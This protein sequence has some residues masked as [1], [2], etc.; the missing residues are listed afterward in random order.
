MSALNSDHGE[1][2]E[3][4][5]S[6]QIVFNGSAYV[7]ARVEIDH[8]NY[9]LNPKTKEL[10]K[11]ARTDFTPDEIGEFLMRLDGEFLMPKSKKGTMARF[12]ADVDCPLNRRFHNKPFRMV[13][14]TNE[15]ETGVF[16][17]ITAFP[18]W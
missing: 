12:V 1:T 11:K 8:I 9:G 13:F 16:L 4:Q 6:K 18:N 5:L 7:T 2:V 3:I 14:E 15:D 10:N 17:V